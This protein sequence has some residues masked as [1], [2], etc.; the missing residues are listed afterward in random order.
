MVLC[1][2]LRRDLEAVEVQGCMEGTRRVDL[3]EDAVYMYMYMYMYRY[4]YTIL[5][6]C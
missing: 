4:I 1:Q 5:K 2:A 3:V 6:P